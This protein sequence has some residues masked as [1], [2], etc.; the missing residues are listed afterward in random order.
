MVNVASDSVGALRILLARLPR[1]AKRAVMICADALA[2]PFCVVAAFWMI[3]SDQTLIRSEMWLVVLVSVCA[4][5]LFAYLGL[6]RSIV[7]FM[8]LDLVVAAFKGVSLLAL[9]SAGLLFDLQQPEESLRVAVGFWAVGLVWVAGSRFAVRLFFQAAKMLGDRVIIYGAGAAGAR[10]ASSLAG[11]QGF[12]PMAYVDDDP[13]QIGTAINGLEVYDPSHLSRLVTELSVSR[14]LLAM[15]SV[16]RRRRRQILNR[17]EAMPVHVQT[18]P[19]ISDLISGFARVDDILEVD[20]A[21]LLGRDAIPPNNELLS[22]CIGAR[23]VM[24]TGAGG[25]IGSELCRQILRQG[26]K[27]LVL[28]DISEAALYTVNQQ[29]REAARR[30]GLGVEI[31]P[32][33]GSVH[34]RDRMRDV[35]SAY[36]VDILYHAAAY[37]HVPLVEH[38]MIEGIHNNA[39]GTLHAAEAALEAGVKS[40]VL[41]ST[42]KAVGPTNVMGATKRLAELILQGLHERAVDTTFSMVRFGNVLASSGSVVPLFREQIRAGGPVTV[43]HPEIIRYF[44]TI[45]EA[46]Q[47]VIQAGAMAQ[48]GDVFVLDMGKPVRIKD[49]AEKMIHLMGLSIRDDD[50]PDGDIEIV[51]TG[52]RPAEK[53]YEE[54]LIG[55]NVSGTEHPMIMRAEEEFL[56][57]HDLQPLL[58]ELWQSC[59]ALDCEKSRQL[60]LTSV[61]GYAPT[62]ELEDLVWRERNRGNPLQEKKAATVTE[63]QGYRG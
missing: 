31:V 28:L 19:D 59:V 9:V 54:L 24:V 29:L 34:H 36:K 26:P 63:L 16:T 58:G 27:R 37:K 44:M 38:N 52:L 7:R 25:S 20:V 11:G 30:D 33:I 41:V 5:P 10:L 46:A 21:D 40:F 39:F 57:W 12:V 18:V 2:L 56:P 14:V 13:S 35:L 53:L 3:S 50:H 55:N 17:L 8:G 23:S 61:D 1:R 60:L 51:Y 62:V 4:M 22:T 48:G 49:L 45:P 42:D 47:L 6:Y 43:T 15:P 32:L